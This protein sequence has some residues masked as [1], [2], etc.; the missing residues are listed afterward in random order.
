MPE[1]LREAMAL[2]KVNPATEVQIQKGREN[3]SE[4]EKMDV[5]IIG[6]GPAGIACAYT[7]AKAGKEVLVI[8]RAETPGGK[9]VTGGRA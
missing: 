4:A 2:V 3:M 5:I 6:A 7:L 8:E 9:N 1:R